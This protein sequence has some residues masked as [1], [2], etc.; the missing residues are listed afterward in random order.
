[1]ATVDKH[2]QI[3]TRGLDRRSFLTK[4]GVGTAGVL[5]LSKIEA[6]AETVEGPV[7]TAAPDPRFSRMFNLPAF[8]NPTSTSVK[9]AMIDIGK[10]GGLLDARD[11]LAEGPVRLIT[12][13]ELSPRNPDS[14]VTDMTAGTTFF[15][16]FID[17]D[18]TFDNSSRLGVVT[19]PTATTNVRDAR[20]DLDSVY[21]GGPSVNPQFYLSSDRRSSLS[22]VAGGSR[23]CPASAAACGPPS[24][25]RATTRT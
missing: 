4:V 24:A 8:A 21:A 12:N 9:N 16:Q 22:A 6:L 15:G 11:P 18:V 7:V 10:T 2:A 5:T 14:A 13:P 17:H 19:E 3:Q 23:I 20:L 25:T 1:M